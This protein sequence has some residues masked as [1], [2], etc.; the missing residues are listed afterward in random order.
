MNLISHVHGLRL[1]STFIKILLI[2]ALK[3]KSSQFFK[4]GVNSKYFNLTMWPRPVI[5]TA[6]NTGLDTPKPRQTGGN[7]LMEK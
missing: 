6:I 1:R 7:Y 3:Q 5:L 2:Y 4:F